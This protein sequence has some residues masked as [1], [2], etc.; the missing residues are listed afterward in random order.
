MS[1]CSLANLNLCLQI[2]NSQSMHCHRRKRLR[3]QVEILKVSSL[4]NWL[5]KVTMELTFPKFYQAMTSSTKPYASTHSL[6]HSPTPAHTQTQNSHTHTEHSYLPPP[7]FSY[8]P[9]THSKSSD[10]KTFIPGMG[11]GGERGLGSGRGG[12]YTPRGGYAFGLM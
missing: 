12:L 11:G 4:L 2:K 5:C 8:S 9:Y 1:V 6:P 3:R 10:Y 7:P